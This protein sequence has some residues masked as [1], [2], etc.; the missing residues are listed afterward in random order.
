MAD[1]TIFYAS[2]QEGNGMSR[3]LLYQAAQIY[4]GLD[5]EKLGPLELNP[6][7]KPFFSLHSELYFSVTHSN[8]WWLCAFSR[9]PVGL[10]LQFHHSYAPPSI[11]SQRFFH[12]MENQF[13]SHEDYRRFFDLWCAK[14]SW[15]K[16]LGK[17]FF[18]D[19]E[20]FSVVSEDGSFPAMSGACLRL[21]PFRADYSLCLCTQ[22]PASVH[23]SSLPL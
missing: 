21:L 20:S 11:L 4:T 6:W 12:P 15:V 3:S 2:S 9:H 17:G 8:K 19:P 16:F 23:F 10:D 22:S 18:E 5:R 1:I 14:E 13:L 7:G